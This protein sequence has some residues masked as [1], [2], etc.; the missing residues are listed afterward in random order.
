[1]RRTFF[2]SPI[3]SPYDC[4]FQLFIFDF[5][6]DKSQGFLLC[7]CGVFLLIL[8]VVVCFVS[9]CVGVLRGTTT[10]QLCFGFCFR[11]SRVLRLPS[12]CARCHKQLREF[13]ACSLGCSEQSIP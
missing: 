9:S 1:M 10:Y 3:I 13:L 4:V 8:V 11:F 5:F 7:L 2:V 12:D 6:G